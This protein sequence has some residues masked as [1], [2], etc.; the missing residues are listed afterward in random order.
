MRHAGLGAWRVTTRIPDGKGSAAAHRPR[1]VV[2]RPARVTRLAAHLCRVTADLEDLADLAD[3]RDRAAARGV[4]SRMLM[5][6]TGAA[7]GPTIS[8]DG[9]V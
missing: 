5:V 9:H 7:P 3:P 4:P 8:A 6:S 1:G 2:G